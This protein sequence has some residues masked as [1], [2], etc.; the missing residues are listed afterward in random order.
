MSWRPYQQRRL[1]EEQAYLRYYLPD[2]EFYSPV[3]DTYVSGWWTSNL[4]R[5]YQI[6][7]H[8][9]GAYPDAPPNTYVCYPT[10][11]YGYRGQ[12]LIESYGNSHSMHT[13]ESDRPGW[14]KVC[15]MRPEH[16]SGE[17][18]IVKILRKAMLW[19]TAYECHLD[20]GRPIREFLMDA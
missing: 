2:F 8:L 15:I 16:W 6:Q 5:Q 14:V 4:R 11:L 17:Y 13:W 20:D 10:P 7:V 9:P 12:K 3:R 18:S 1:A 19:I